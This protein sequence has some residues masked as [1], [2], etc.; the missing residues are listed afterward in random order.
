MITTI[1]T[2]A[3]QNEK[4]NEAPRD[5][6]LKILDPSAIE[7]AIASDLNMLEDANRFLPKK[8]E[9]QNGTPD[10]NQPD[11]SQRFMDIF[12]H[13]MSTALPLYQEVPPE[14]RERVLGDLF[15]Q[16][17]PEQGP[18]SRARL[19]AIAEAFGDIR[20]FSDEI[21][22][23]V[24]ERTLKVFIATLESGSCLPNELTPVLSQQDLASDPV[25]T[26]CK[27]YFTRF[28]H[29]RTTSDQNDHHSIRTPTKMVL[30]DASFAGVRQLLLSDPEIQNHAKHYLNS[31]LRSPNAE[32]LQ[33][34][35]TALG[36]DSYL[37]SDPFIEQVMTR[38]CT[39]LTPDQVTR[40]QSVSLRDALEAAKLLPWYVPETRMVPDS[41]ARNLESIHAL[42]GAAVVQHML[43]LNGSTLSAQ[44]FSQSFYAIRPAV[45]LLTSDSALNK[46]NF[47]PALRYLSNLIARNVDNPNFADYA[48]ELLHLAP[49]SA[50]EDI[51]SGLAES[52]VSYATKW[53]RGLAQ[54]RSPLND[55]SGSKNYPQAPADD[56]TNA[57]FDAIAQR[58]VATAAEGSTVEQLI[59]NLRLP[60]DTPG[61]IK[62][63][64]REKLV[65]Q[66]NSAQLRQRS[67]LSAKTSLLSPDVKSMGTLA[68]HFR[69]ASITTEEIHCEPGS[70]SGTLYEAAS[71]IG[72]ICK[73][74]D[75][76]AFRSSPS[77][78][79][80]VAEAVKVLGS[81][82][83]ARS[84]PGISRKA[85]LQYAQLIK[86]S[87]VEPLD[88]AHD[89]PESVPPHV[90]LDAFRSKAA[91][92]L[93]W[94]RWGDVTLAG[95][96]WREIQENYGGGAKSQQFNDEIDKINEQ[97]ARLSG[98]PRLQL[99]NLQARVDRIQF[100]DL[101]GYTE[102]ALR[103]LLGQLVTLG[104]TYL[105]KSMP[106]SAAARASAIKVLSDA[107]LVERALYDKYIQE[108]IF[109]DSARSRFYSV[110]LH[111]PWNV[112]LLKALAL[113]ENYQHKQAEEIVAEALKILSDFASGAIKQLAN[114]PLGHFKVSEYEDFKEL[115]FHV[116]TRAMDFSARGYF[117]PAANVTEAAIS[118]QKAYIKFR[119][120]IQSVSETKREEEIKDVMRLI[121]MQ[122]SVA[123][124]YHMLN[125]RQQALLHCNEAIK[126]I[127][128]LTLEPLTYDQQKIIKRIQAFQE[129]LTAK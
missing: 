8:E 4:V 118:Y 102:D 7:Q 20:G 18:I 129:E 71:R 57:I 39:A 30:N 107:E 74:L 17:L 55:G 47:T 44:S 114:E 11:F 113:F 40:D 52:A 100:A 83:L 58:L 109:N 94:R 43:S 46:Y 67:I 53:I 48:R 29:E 111:A 86:K 6:F 64:L 41:T 23:S 90:N 72:F 14:Q 104:E 70:G 119:R 79:K 110:D 22:Q 51:R 80:D 28:L 21:R 45:E 5:E 10:R 91:Q 66:K 37:A 62:T 76:G 117:A 78:Q 36:L 126:E 59:R 61:W 68:R 116:W 65:T 33:D 123:K 115:A 88:T 9:G 24:Q 93:M 98:D 99:A 106:N 56:S 84:L 2:S 16:M 35:A 60:T 69:V 19:Q 73:Q 128:K 1:P 54:P 3:G 12:R 92:F 87:F 108:G 97:W 121:R 89:T 96:V 34:E 26:A 127:E 27:A 120:S 82:A 38:I 81:D 125:H 31:L 77:I 101:A 13:R 49:Q 75:D 124:S 15:V 50:R 122:E 63:D 42:A 112:R 103:T 85:L 25:F 32:Q 95:L 105:K